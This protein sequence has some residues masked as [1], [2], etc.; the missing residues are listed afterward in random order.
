LVLMRKRRPPFTLLLSALVAAAA[1]VITLAG[2]G[3]TH[4]PATPTPPSIGIG[5][6]RAC[7]TTGAAAQSDDRSAIVVNATVQA[8]VRVTEQASGPNGTATVTRSK[9][10]S[11]RASADE[12]VAVK[13]TSAARVRACAEGNSMTAARTTALRAAY[14][15]ALSDAKG[16]AAH[17]AAQSLTELVHAEYPAVLAAAKSKAAAR[18]HQLALTA[19]ALLAAQARTQALQRAGD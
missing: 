11:A 13:H 15:R 4:R 17:Q 3:S 14:A 18:A 9:L 19:G 8:P 16:L 6:T 1:L 5:S 10:V 2:R 7:V 12:P